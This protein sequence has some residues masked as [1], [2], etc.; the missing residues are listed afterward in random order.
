M[1]KFIA[2]SINEYNI[3]WLGVDNISLI[4]NT[5]TSL[6]SATENNMTVFA[7]NGHIHLSNI[8][9]GSTYE[10]F[11]M[12]GI[13]RVKGSLSSNSQEISLPQKGIYLVK[14]IS[15][16]IVETKKVIW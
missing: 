11:D 2:K 12:K 3:Y 8:K 7:H 6:S 1:L 9:Q 13:L 10:V 16:D 15:N 5:T 14:V 4:A